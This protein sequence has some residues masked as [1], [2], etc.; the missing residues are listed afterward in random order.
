MYANDTIT[1]VLS[2]DSWNIL[3]NEAVLLDENLQ[4]IIH[5]IIDNT[6]FINVI[7]NREV[8]IRPYRGSSSSKAHSH[9]KKKF[10]RRTDTE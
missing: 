4:Y 9:Y 8:V 1:V 6:I 3:W 10:L 2:I 5:E 7:S